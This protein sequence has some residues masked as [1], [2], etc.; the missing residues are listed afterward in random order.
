MEFKT[1]NRI[2]ISLL[3]RKCQLN[4][5]WIFLPLDVFTLMF[6]VNAPL[7]RNLG[8]SWTWYRTQKEELKRNN[9]DRYSYEMQQLSRILQCAQFPCL[10]YALLSD[11]VFIHARQCRASFEHSWKLAKFQGLSQQHFEKLFFFY[12]PMIFFY[13]DI[14]LLRCK[15]KKKTLHIWGEG[16]VNTPY[17]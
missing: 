2:K 1:E 17:P 6:H 7:P 16:V 8:I 15:K 14:F 4:E 5:Y 13:T 11:A 9:I 3:L 10:I 12:T